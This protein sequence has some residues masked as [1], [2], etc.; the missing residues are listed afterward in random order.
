MVILPKL[1]RLSLFFLPF[2]WEVTSTFEPVS[3]ASIQRTL[4]APCCLCPFPD[5]FPHEDKIGLVLN[6]QGMECAD[7]QESIFLLDEYDEQCVA[8]QGDFSQ[9]CCTSQ[10]VQPAT[11]AP[12]QSPPTAPSVTQQ[13]TEPICHLC[14]NEAY[15]ARHH[16]TI[17]SQFLEGPKSCGQLYDMGL[18]GFIQASLCYSLYLYAVDNCCF[19][20]TPITTAPTPAPSISSPPSVTPSK[21]PSQEPVWQ[22]KDFTE[23]CTTTSDC[24]DQSHVCRWSGD[25]D[26]CR[27]DPN[28]F[29]EGRE[30]L[31]SSYGARVRGS[32]NYRRG[33]RG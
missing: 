30:K 20:E 12:Q 11:N 14:P 31:G 21:L 15:P 16:V 8:A 32:G 29:S 2:I 4:S 6:D 28:V 23:V 9:V 27:S 25:T 7:V 13:G 17:T 24:C 22:C 19:S 26:R 18:D 3:R 10:E 5:C 33:L 1:V